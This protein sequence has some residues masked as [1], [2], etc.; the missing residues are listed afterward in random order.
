MSV[1][2]QDMFSAL[3]MAAGLGKTEIVVELVKAGANVDMQ[4]DVRSYVNT[5]VVH[6]VHHLQRH[7]SL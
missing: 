1:I 5:F 2:T 6:N 3:M 4:T 7:T